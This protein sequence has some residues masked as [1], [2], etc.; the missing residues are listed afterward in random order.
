MKRLLA[1]LLTGGL[2]VSLPLASPAYGVETAGPDATCSR[3]VSDADGLYLP[4]QAF[5]WSTT[6]LTIG[7]TATSKVDPAQFTAVEQAV[8]TWQQTLQDCLGGAVTLNYVPVVPS[9]RAQIDIVINLVPNAGGAHHGGMAV[10]NPSG[11][12]LQVGYIG[13]RGRYTTID[14]VAPTSYTYSL[15]LHEIGHALGLGHTTNLYESVTDV[16]GYGWNDDSGRVPI[17]QCNV[18]ALA[19]IW[20]WALNG[21][22]PAEPEALVYECA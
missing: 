1:M 19:Y 10:C 12:N 18:D 20:A 17:S 22:E 11:C 8:E 6:E 5:W 16:M 3:P 9:K 14:P 2:L 4:A 7:I 21:T 15:A 13:P